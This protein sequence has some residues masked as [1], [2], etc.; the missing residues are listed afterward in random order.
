[1]S[2]T[3]LVVDFCSY[4]AAKFAVEH[5][6]YSGVIPAG[7]TVKIGVWEGGKFIGAVIYSRG[8]NNNIGKPY[9][10]KQTEVCELV[11]V[12]LTSHV[13]PVSQIVSMAQKLLIATS[14][15]LRLIVSYADP[16]Q[17]HNGAIYQAMNWLYVGAVG[18]TTLYLHRGQYVHQRTASSFY[19]SIEGLPSKKLPNKHKYLYPLDRAM[20][21]QIEPLAKPYPKK[22]DMPPVNGDN[23]A[24]S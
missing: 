15:G 16:E 7:K 14:P 4:Q 18:S 20:R 23:L 19:K 24:T 12:A 5:W 11:R 21:R 1:M 2:K 6:H 8:A 17:G 22:L 9:N 10:L 3:N 13:A